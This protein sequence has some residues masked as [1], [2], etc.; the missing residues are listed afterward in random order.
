M[1]VQY[2]RVGKVK[3][4]QKIWN[5]RTLDGA[6]Q[7]KLADL[8]GLD[9]FASG[10]GAVSPASWRAYVTRR[11]RDMGLGAQSTVFEIGCGAGAFLWVL[12]ERGCQVAGLD[13]AANL[14][15]VAARAMPDGLWQVGE[16][17]QVIGKGR[18]DAVVANSVWHYFQS[19]EYAGR[20]LQN[21][22]ETAKSA[23]AVLDVPNLN[24]AAYDVANR[25]AVL[26]KEEY[27]R[28]YAG[29]THLAVAPDWFHGFG[30]KDWE[31]KT[32][33]Q[34]IPEYGN[35]SYRFNVII[36]RRHN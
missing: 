6:G 5:T 20:V 4:W 33:A 31:V 32:A 19:L 25:R 1:A 7:P 9:G 28:R 27:D 23:V 29:L 30:G 16:A 35:N 13:Y 3:N 21:M 24:L 34:D 12:R 18:Y 8:L 2:D 26:G 36:K 10:V 17:D 15:A 14:I 22:L 11:A